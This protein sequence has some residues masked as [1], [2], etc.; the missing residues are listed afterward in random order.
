[1]CN[2]DWYSEISI[3]L[4]NIVIRCNNLP[5]RNTIQQFTILIFYIPYGGKFSRQ[6]TLVNL[7]NCNVPVGTANN[8][9]DCNILHVTMKSL[10]VIWGT[11]SLWDLVY[12]LVFVFTGTK[13]VCWEGRYVP[14]PHD[15]FLLSA[16]QFTASSQGNG[17]FMEFICLHGADSFSQKSP[18]FYLLTLF[19]LFTKVFLPIHYFAHLPRFSTIW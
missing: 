14:Y 9:R 18:N 6:K 15:S 11:V 13:W 2:M 3:W 19:H 12:I 17:K 4:C 8:A 5:Y 10:L 1:M 7:A 16:Y